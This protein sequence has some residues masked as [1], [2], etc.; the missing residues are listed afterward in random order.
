M[1]EGLAK[2]RSAKGKAPLFEIF[3][4]EGYASL[5]RALDYALAH[6]LGLMEATD[7][8]V[9]MANEGFT[10]LDNLRA[11]FLKNVDFAQAGPPPSAK[12]KAPVT[13]PKTKR[14]RSP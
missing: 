6:G 8:V 11:H 4:E 5:N 14:V 3:D 7:L 9:P 1:L 12:K 13:K 10:D 2:P